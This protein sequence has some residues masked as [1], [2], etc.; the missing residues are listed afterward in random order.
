MILSFCFRKWEIW[1]SQPKGPLLKLPNIYTTLWSSKPIHLKTS[2]WGQR[3]TAIL[4][5]AMTLEGSPFPI[6]LNTAPAGQ[7]PVWRGHQMNKPLIPRR[8]PTQLLVRLL[9]L[10]RIS[11]PS[12]I[13][14]GWGSGYARVYAF[15][16]LWY[17]TYCKL[18]WASDSVS[19][20]GQHNEMSINNDAS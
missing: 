9:K 12:W 6:E 5:R 11:I 2:L 8:K 15:G 1:Y 18:N 16:P 20:M 7:R 10:S 17:H 19:I 13:Q 14:G 3:R 4:L